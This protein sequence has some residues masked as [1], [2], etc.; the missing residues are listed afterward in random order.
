MHGQARVRAHRLGIVLPLLLALMATA[1]G[2]AASG[3][4]APGGSADLKVTKTANTTSVPVGGTITYTIVVENLGPETATGVT[5][6]DALPNQ[7]DYAAATS[8][9]GTCKKQGQK[10][11]CDIGSLE[12]GASAKVSKATITLTVKASKAGTASNTAAVKGDQADPT[13]ANN[14]ATAVVTIV[15]APKAA[16]C[17]GYAATVV[18][19]AAGETLMGTPGRDVIAALGGSDSVFALGGNDLVCAGGGNDLVKAG[20]G[21]DRV[22]GVGG[23]DR[24]LGGA[25][26]DLLK[27]GAGGDRLKGNAGADRL[28]GGRGVDTCRGGA[29]VDSVRGCER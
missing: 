8:T 24:L 16:T 23:R 13:S 17:R 22:F 2:F 26:P 3:T 28:R 9:A 21:T 20:G 14:T 27:G 15:A 4:A 6:S 19:T 1:L 5:M 12:A 10:A 11:V 18:G 7:V 29:G 25:G